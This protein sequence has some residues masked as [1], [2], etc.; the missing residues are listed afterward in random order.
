MNFSIKGKVIKVLES[1][2]GTSQASGNEWKKQS[3]VIETDGQY[4]KK[5]CFTA[6]NDRVE[7]VEKMVAGMEAEVSFRAESRE[8]N[9]RWY[10][11]LTAYEIKLSG[12]GEAPSQPNADDENDDIP[13]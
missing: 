5:V 2:S 4:P 8:Y 13:F 12:E 7:D 3:F 10:T 11:D 6:W 1:A 9:E